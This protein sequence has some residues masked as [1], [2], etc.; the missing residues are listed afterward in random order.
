M[1]ANADQNIAGFPVRSG[2]LEKGS[3]DWRI[4]KAPESGYALPSRGIRQPGDNGPLVIANPRIRFYLAVSN[5][6][7]AIVRLAG[8]DRE[9]CFHAE[10]HLI[11]AMD[12][13]LHL[14]LDTEI[15]KGE[16][17]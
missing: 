13:R 5:N 16:R 17:R 2:L 7:N 15:F 10:R 1:R 14:Y 8:E 6:R 4:R 12:K 9:G 3:E 11:R